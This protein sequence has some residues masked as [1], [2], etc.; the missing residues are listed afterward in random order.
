MKRFTPALAPI[1]APIIHIK[2]KGMCPSFSA[3]DCVKNVQSV[4]TAAPSPKSVLR[5]SEYLTALGSVWDRSWSYHISPK[6]RRI[7][8]Y[9][10]RRR[11]SWI[12]KLVNRV[13][14]YAKGGPVLFGDAANSGLFGRVGGAGVK[15]PM[16]EIKKRLSKQLPVIECS[17]FRTSMLCLD[18]G[19]AAKFFNYGVT[20]CTD[21]GR[22]RMANRDVAAAKTDRG[23]LSGNKEGI[24]PRPMVSERVGRC[25]PARHTCEHGS[26]RRADVL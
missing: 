25:H 20:Y 15:G 16:L 12:V 4:L 10:W 22:H 14:A 24:E 1:L 3:E 21:P 26:P 6:L 9:A 18:C 23:A 8:F 2:K 19:C 13:K 7:K 17:V 11:E 5:Y